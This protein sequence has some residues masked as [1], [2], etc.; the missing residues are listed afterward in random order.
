MFAV[1]LAIGVVLLSR[2]ECRFLQSL[3]KSSAFAEL[4]VHTEFDYVGYLHCAMAPAANS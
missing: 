2:R 4:I 1:L 3:P